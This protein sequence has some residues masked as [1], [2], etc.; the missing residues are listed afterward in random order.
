M[1]RPDTAGIKSRTYHYGVP[2][3]ANSDVRALCEYIEHLEATTPAPVEPAGLPGPN[4]RI[5]HDP[6]DADPEEDD[7][8]LQVR[9]PKNGKFDADN[10]KFVGC[11]ATEQLA[12]EALAGLLP[13]PA[14]SPEQARDLRAL[15]LL[16]ER[17]DE[18]DAIHVL[19]DGEGFEVVVVTDA[20]PACARAADLA[21]AILRTLGDPPKEPTP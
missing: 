17:I 2:V 1:E 20:W 4:I 18:V 15:E 16:R 11:F 3:I 8:W 10:W 14:L 12:Q 19:D 5:I 7:W 13:T 6:D 9:I 21:T